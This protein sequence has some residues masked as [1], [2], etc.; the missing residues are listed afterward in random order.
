MERMNLKDHV[1]FKAIS[2]YGQVHIPTEMREKLDIEDEGIYAM[3]VL[4]PLVTK[5][6]SMT[7]E[8]A[9]E[10]LKYLVSQSERAPDEV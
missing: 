6:S 2:S 10:Y 7:K 5:S 9:Y 3:I 8:E 1:F 4:I